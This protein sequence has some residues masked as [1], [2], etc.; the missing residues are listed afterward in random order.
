MLQA[1]LIELS[2]STWT[3]R[4]LDRKVSKEVTTGKAADSN[5]ARVNKHLFVGV[6]LLEEI[7]ALASTI[8][9]EFYRQTLPWSDAGARLLP[10]SQFFVYKQ[11][12][13]DM[14]QIFATKVAAFVQAYPTLVGAQAFRLGAMFD[15]AEYP[16]PDQIAS[17]FRL[18]CTYSPLPTTGDF[19]VDVTNDVEKEL[20]DQYEQVYA[21]RLDSAVGDLWDRLHAVLTRISDRLTTG[22]GEKKIFRDSMVDNAI[23][24][25]DMLTRLNVTNDATLEQARQRLEQVLS[26]VTADDLRQSEATVVTV[27]TEVDRLLEMFT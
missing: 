5:A 26:G 18:A 8:R 19:R 1:I 20:R 10:M 16:A 11:W 12:A 4:K 3:A 22:P 24:L 25:C 2:I 6:Q 14:E 15:R 13:N 27:R 9:T 17:K 21:S 23:E 7:A